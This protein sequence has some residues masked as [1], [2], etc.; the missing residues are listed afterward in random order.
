MENKVEY[1]SFCQTITVICGTCGMNS[2]SGGSGEDPET[3]M[4][5]LD[6]PQAALEASELMPA[7]ARIERASKNLA[8]ARKA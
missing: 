7:D 4:T 2:C 3:G 8:S 6:C 5:C 1:C